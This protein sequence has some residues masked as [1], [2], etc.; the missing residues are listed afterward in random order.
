[1]YSWLYQ[2]TSPFYMASPR[3]PVPVG[4]AANSPRP[5]SRASA[6]VNFHQGFRRYRRSKDEKNVV[7]YHLYI[8]FIPF[9]YHLYELI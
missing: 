2:Q 1:M 5:S 3:V 7:I 6:V 9:I 8:P 4:P